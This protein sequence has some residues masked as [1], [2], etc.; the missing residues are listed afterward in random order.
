M[1]GQ[2]VGTDPVTG[3]AVLDLP[4]AGYPTAKPAGSVPGRGTTVVTVAVA[5]A[6]AEAPS[7]TGTGT[8]AAAG[9]GA[10]AGPEA[11]EATPGRVGPTRRLTGE[12]PVPIEGVVTV[13][14]ESEGEG[15]GAALGAATVDTDGDLLGVT[16][17]VTDGS[18][19]YTVP[20]DVVDKVT[21]D[22]LADGRAHHSWLGI[23]GLD[24]TTDP[25]KGY[26]L[27]GAETQGVVVSSVDPDGPGAAAGLQ[28]ADVIL[29][30][31]GR[32]VTTMPDLVRWLRACSPGEAAVLDI[33]RDG[34]ESTVEVTLGVLATPA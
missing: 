2:L 14:G 11:W 22:L 32:P 3:L 26:G 23:D 25:S 30:I 19:S 31:D 8:A 17:A 1:L 29:A 34:A 27:L 10:G 5:E 21:D 18:T 13:D 9:P 33:R 24:S 20:L 6:E 16:T 7:G 4:G 28:R 12:G 15:G